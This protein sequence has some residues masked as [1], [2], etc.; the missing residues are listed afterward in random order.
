[1]MPAWEGSIVPPDFHAHMREKARMWEPYQ[2]ILGKDF[3]VFEFDNEAGRDVVHKNLKHYEAS[4]GYTSYVGGCD[5]LVIVKGEPY[6][7]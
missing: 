1:M 5:Q 4:Y 2:V 6:A 3:A 7:Q